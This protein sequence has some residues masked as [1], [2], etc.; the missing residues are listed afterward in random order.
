MR[1]ENYTPFPNLRF[2]GMDNRGREFGVLLVK[3]T[4]VVDPHG[5][6]SVAGDQEPLVMTDTYHGEL[7]TSSLHLPSDIV[8]VK[9]RSDIIINAVARAPA[10]KPSRSWTCAVRVQGDHVVE[11][12]IRVTGPREWHPMWGV[13][14]RAKATMTEA[15]RRRVFG[16]WRLSEPEPVSELPIRYE[17]AFGGLLA[18]P[19]QD[20]AEPF[21]APEQRNPV[22]RGWIDPDLTPRDRPVP[23]P[24][25]ED[26]DV[27][28]VDPF[29]R[30]APAGFGPIPP[31]WLP[32]RPLGGT[33]DQH[34]RENVWPKWPEDYDFAYHNSAHPD[35]IYPGLLRGHETITLSGLGGESGEET[36]RLPVQTAFLTIKNAKGDASSMPM[37]LDTLMLDI[38]DESTEQWRIFLTWRSTFE[39][40]DVAGLVIDLLRYPLTHIAGSPA[41]RPGAPARGSLK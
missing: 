37:S 36:V 2:F 33:F 26:A 10:G 38:A 35:M 17:F 12:R 22:G 9:P 3:G 30:P 14:E 27:P 31:A 24:Q 29:A 1:M 20:G 28:I 32:R 11:K 21:L 6:L 13:S 23:A 34:W 4:Y 18:R 40:A 19:Q 39:H 41:Y 5:W 15:E 16:G 25:I 8:P 7:N